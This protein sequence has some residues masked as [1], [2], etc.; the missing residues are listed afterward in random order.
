MIALAAFVPQIRPVYAQMQDEGTADGLNLVPRGVYMVNV[1]RA[2]DGAPGDFIMHGSNIG[3]VSGCIDVTE[4]EVKVV[5]TMN[6]VEISLE[7]D[8][9]FELKNDEVRYGTYSCDIKTR[10]A[11]FDVRLN[12]DE[13]IDRNIKSIG[14]KSK[15]YGMYTDTKINPSK[16]KIE[17]S[18]QSTAG[19][20]FET[21]WFY[22]SNT[23]ILHTPGAK[24]DQDVG[25]LIDKFAESKGLV[26][27]SKTLKGFTLPDTAMN[28]KYYTD[29]RGSVIHQL[30]APD[31]NVKVGMLTAQRTFYGSDGAL[32]Q[33]YTLDVYALKPGMND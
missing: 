12:R 21:F 2:S 31:D 5:F 16:D 19:S 14:V 17:F 10:T 6:K 24:R 18:S 7:K 33:S 25:P 29:P 28:I 13:L 15:T 22:P 3:T 8:S 26:P 11:T 23:V 30:S 32:T 4:P 27:L 1:Q 9:E 20:Y